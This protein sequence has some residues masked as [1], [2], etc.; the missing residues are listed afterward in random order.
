MSRAEG[1]S[2]L[3]DLEKMQQVDVDLKEDELKWCRSFPT[4]STL[5]LEVHEGAG[6]KLA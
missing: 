1:L 2:L 6:R 5:H 4:G 3:G